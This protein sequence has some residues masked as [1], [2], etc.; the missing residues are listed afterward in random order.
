MAVAEGEGGSVLSYRVEQL[1]L[2]RHWILE[3]TKGILEE[4]TQAERERARARERERERE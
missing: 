2:L 4:L 1:R 3:H